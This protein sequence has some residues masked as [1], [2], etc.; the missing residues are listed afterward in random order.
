MDLFPPSSDNVLQNGTLL[1][2]D[3]SQKVSK[4]SKQS[5]GIN[6]LI[7]KI[8]LIWEGKIM[9]RLDLEVFSYSKV[10]FSFPVLSAWNF[11]F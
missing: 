6:K 5:K 4:G 3:K 11:S 2:V 9:E 10:F 8:L 1:E 7:I